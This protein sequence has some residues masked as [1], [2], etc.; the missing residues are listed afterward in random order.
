MK[1]ITILDAARHLGVKEDAQGNIS[2][3]EFDKVGLPFFC[4]CEICEASLGP[5]NAFPTYSGYTRC[6]DCVGDVGFASAEMFS[7][8]LTREGD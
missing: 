2:M 7:D 8:W 4:G 1:A 6:K 3:G 5:F